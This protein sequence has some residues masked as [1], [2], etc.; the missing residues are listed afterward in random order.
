MKLRWTIFLG[1]CAPVTEP[2]P[3]A[4][5]FD[6]APVDSASPEDTAESGTIGEPPEPTE[7]VLCADPSLRDSLGP[8]E[9]LVLPEL[10]LQTYDLEPDLTNG[11]GLAVGDVDGDGRLD[12]VLPHAGPSQLLMQQDDGSFV[13]ETDARW[14][15]L[16]D[17]APG[18]AAIHMVDI[19]GDT[20]LD[21]FMCGGPVMGD[22]TPS[23]HNQLF[24]NDGTGHFDNVSAEWGL[25]DDDMR[26]CFG[27]AFGDIDGD[28]DL[29]MATAANEAC[30]YIFE[31]EAQDCDLLLEQS[32]SRVLWENTGTSLEDV[33][34]RLPLETMLSSF[35]HV[36]TF[37]DIDGDGDLDLY[38]TND[39]K[40]T[41]SFS[42]ANLLFLND[43]TG[44]FNTP[45]GYHGLDFSI[46][47][48]GLGV[49]D[50]ND[51]RLPDLILS[52]TR[53][54]ALMMSDADH[55]WYDAA[56]ASGVLFDDPSH[57]EAWATDFVDIDNDT[58]LDIPF[59]FGWLDGDPTDPVG[60]FQPDALFM[61]T[62]DDT[63]VDVAADWGLDDRGI[64]RGM[65]VVDLDGDGWLDL[66]KRE[67]GGDVKAYRARCGGAHW[68]H[69][70]LFQAT[71]NTAALGA[72]VEVT[73]AAGT[74]RRWVLGAGTL[75]ASNAATGL[76][77]GLGDATMLDSVVVTWPDQTTTTWTDLPVDR[78][79]RL[80]RR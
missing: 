23:V 20:D 80:E 31:L 17:G 4:S 15:G 19:D 29:D 76:H 37:L 36:T 47:G 53:R 45:T 16:T 74:Q 24:L 71:E 52:G 59:V 11:S 46:A 40:N 34:H 61:N 78:V 30:P 14:S 77:F 3:L 41:V 62:G 38:F 27:A 57:I 64:G 70:D 50:L 56:T 68:T 55:G 10:H 28:G 39:D 9:P 79:L 67:L 1:A 26:P 51:D 54:A 6:R 33:S 60:Y 65:V 7:E 75:F 42:E 2:L 73:T 12:I 48:M 58:H 13:D 18:S 69:I 22:E 5:S 35:T 63:W 21:L 49:A 8:F 72:M 25:E 44:H 66:L 43:G 32:S